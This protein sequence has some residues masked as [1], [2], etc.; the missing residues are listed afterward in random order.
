LR[1]ALNWPSGLLHV[2]EDGFL[3][4][5][6]KRRLTRVGPAEEPSPVLNATFGSGVVH[7]LTADA[8][9]VRSLTLVPQS[10]TAAEG[11]QFLLRLGGRLLVGG[12]S[13]VAVYRP[14]RTGRTGDAVVSLRELSVTHMEAV[15]ASDDAGVLATL[16]DGTF[17]ALAVDERDQVS[18]VAEYPERPW[19]ADAVQLGDTFVIVNDRGASLEV[20]RASTSQPVGADSA[21]ELPDG[22]AFASWEDIGSD[23]AVGTLHG[24]E[25]RLEGSPGIDGVTDG[26]FTLFAAAHFS[27][28]LPASDAVSLISLAGSSF[29]L[30]LRAGPR[31]GAAPG[32]RGLE[33]HLPAWDAG[34]ASQRR[35]HVL[36]VRDDSHRRRRWLA[37]LGRNVAHLRHGDGTRAYCGSGVR[38]R[39][40]PRRLY[41]VGGT[42]C[43][44]AWVAEITD[45]PDLTT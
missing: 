9:E 21:A 39:R 30:R 22:F 6:S 5:D 20:L 44:G 2:T 26:T 3:F 38:R 14:T 10:S 15:T 18:V 42:E 31:R 32:V 27:P 17:R 28:P 45:M 41:D 13:G 7:V 43:P 33:H 34:G 24:A 16:A 12:P 25:V 4:I 37:G 19:F 36:A 40:D 35:P 8:L 11:A 29:R 1:S 23:Q